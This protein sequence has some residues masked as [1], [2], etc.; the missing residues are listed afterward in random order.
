M[1]SG[2]DFDLTSIEI[3]QTLLLSF[4]GLRIGQVIFLKKF[5]EV[6]QDCKVKDWNDNRNLVHAER[7]GRSRQ[8]LHPWRENEDWARG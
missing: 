5:P 1:I 8:E 2:L 3:I 6:M 7:A 4:V